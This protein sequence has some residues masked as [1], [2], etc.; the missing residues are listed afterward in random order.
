MKKGVLSDLKPIKIGKKLV[1]LIVLG[2]KI[3]QKILDQK[4]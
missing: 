4:K 2:V 1:L 3:I